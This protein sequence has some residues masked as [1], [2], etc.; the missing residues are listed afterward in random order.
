MFNHSRGFTLIELMIVVAIVAI[1]AS[2]AASIYVDAV[3][4]SQVSEVFTIT[5]GLKTNIA[6]YLGQSGECPQLGKTSGFPSTPAS[7][8]GTYVSGIEIAPIANGCSMTAT[9]RGTGSVTPKLIHQTVTI[10]LDATAS[11][12]QWSCT[13]TVKPVYLPA[14]CR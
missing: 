13:S 4:K 8:G 5:D 1:L 10:S 12:A 14:T 9:M 11:N 7:Y 6:E 2:L 3:S